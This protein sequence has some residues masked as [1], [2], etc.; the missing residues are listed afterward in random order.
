MSRIRSKSFLLTFSGIILFLCIW[1]LVVVLGFVNPVF[2]PSPWSV[3]IAF[4][5]EPGYVITSTLTT[6]CDIAFG[7]FLGVSFALILGIIFG[8]FR[9][10]GTFFRSPI[11]LISPIPIVTFIPLF[12]LWFG[13][14]RVPVL[15]CSSIGAFFPTFLN[16]I[17]GVRHTDKALIDVAKNFQASNSM[18]L[19]KVVLPSASPHIVN[20]LRISMQMAFLITPVAEMIMGDI[21]LGGLIWRSA[22]LFLTDMVLVGQITLGVMGLLLYTV[23][24][25]M[26]KKY[27]ERWKMGDNN[28]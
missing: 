17:S 11:L 1:H 7:Y 25:W 18:I 22:D 3:L 26:E 10:I 28:W 23:L 27:L 19:W 14:G 24:D 15:L 9:S 12:I 16:T 4:L 21:G 6:I 20:G 13:L 5:G 8:W 2:L